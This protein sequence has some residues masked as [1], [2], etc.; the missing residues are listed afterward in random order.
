MKALATLNIMDVL[1][2]GGGELAASLIRY[3][4][5]DRF[6]FFIAPRII[7][8][9]DAVPSVGGVGAGRLSEAVELKN[10]TLNRFKKDILV[11]AEAG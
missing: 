4:L 8:G 10:V 1:V 6:L 9:R 5:V 2:E 3:K 7:G 11:M